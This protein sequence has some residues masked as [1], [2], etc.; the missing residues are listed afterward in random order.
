MKE[1]WRLMKKIGVMIYCYN[2]VENIRTVYERTVNVIEGLTQYQWEI[3]FADNRSTDG[4]DE[5]LRELAAKDHRVKVILNQANYGGTR[6]ASNGLFSMNSDAVILMASDLE[7]PPELIPQF[8]AAWEEGYKVV[9]AQYTSREENILIHA[10]R[11]LYYKIIMAFSEL[12]LEKNVTGFGLFDRS[13]LDILRVI[14]EPEPMLRYLFAELGY[15]IKYI[16][17]HKPHRKK[18]RSSFSIFN[19]YREFIKSLIA[20]S[21]AP[22]HMVSLLGFTVSAV[23]FLIGL[24]YFVLKLVMWGTFDWGIAPLVVG[25]FFLGGVQL[26][27]IGIIGEYL[28]A[29]LTRLTKR[30]YVIERERINFDDAD[31][32]ETEEIKIK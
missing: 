12:K 6:S 16:P 21:Q 19:Y 30:P 20:T 11:Q 25:M 22:L 23:S 32:D 2:E 15:N 1:P 10:F 26:I 3:L 14:E 27:C 28:G 9:L 29:V 13:A 4:T 31:T 5:I 24:F 17:F 18:G 8:L 7:E